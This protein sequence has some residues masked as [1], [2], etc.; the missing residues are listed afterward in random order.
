MVTSFRYLRRLISAADDDWP[1]VVR[2]LSNVRA[3]WRRM[4]RILIMEGAEPRVSVFFSKSII[5][6]VLLFSAVTWVVNYRMGRVLGGFQD[7]V[8]RQ[9][10]GQLP[11]RQADR[12]W[13]YT[14][15]EAEK[16][17]ARFETMEAYI[18]KRQNT[19]VHYIAMQSLLGLF[20]ETERMQGGGE[21]M[22]WWE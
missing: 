19:V 6:S 9:L 2:N 11:R 18:W 21:G 14:L 1:A 13:G 15:T 22:W 17:E 20:E 7:Q 10:T 12:K 3:V 5:K 8:A 16:V 4:T